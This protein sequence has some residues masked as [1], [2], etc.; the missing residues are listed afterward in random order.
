[1]NCDPKYAA[2]KARFGRVMLF[3]LVASF[4]F[5]ASI[6]MVLTNFY[7]GLVAGLVDIAVLLSFRS[8]LRKA[9]YSRNESRVRQIM[10][11]NDLIS[12][13]IISIIIYHGSQNI[14]WA[15]GF[16]IFVIALN[17]LVADR[18]VKAMIVA[19]HSD[20]PTALEQEI[21][22]DIPTLTTDPE[23]FVRN[24]LYISHALLAV[25]YTGILLWI[26]ENRYIA[27][28]LG[29]VIY[30]A[31]LYTLPYRAHAIVIGDRYRNKLLYLI[32]TVASA[33][34]AMVVLYY[35]TQ[36]ILM[37]ITAAAIGLGAM[38]VYASSTDDFRNDDDKGN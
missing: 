6:V 37:A 15:A 1:M 35:E 26:M 22:A 34:L 29:G 10:L 18:A 14:L 31:Q 12:L 4:L 7:Y 21:N 2:F 19:S 24:M 20:N 28:G 8:A 5:I 36:D 11:S 16:P 9:V 33:L 38:S 32:A 25:L 27:I 13:I 3:H 23:K 17:W 30:S